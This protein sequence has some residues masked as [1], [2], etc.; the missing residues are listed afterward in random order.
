MFSHSCFLPAVL[1]AL[2]A[3]VLPILTQ[4]PWFSGPIKSQGHRGSPDISYSS[5]FKTGSRLRHLS[6]ASRA[7]PGLSSCKS[8][9]L[10][11]LSSPRV[12]G[13][14][15]PSA[16]RQDSRLA[17]DFITFLRR[18]EPSQPYPHASPMVFWPH[19]VPESSG[20]FKPRAAGV[21]YS[22]RLETGSRIRRICKLIKPLSQYLTFKLFK[23]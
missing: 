21:N 6:T 11:A 4:V 22:A 5:R 8:H 13:V 18:R 19:Q 17:R 20:F 1:R 7:L 16:T 2:L 3:H 23:I 10:P 14:I 9:G 15:Q 12:V